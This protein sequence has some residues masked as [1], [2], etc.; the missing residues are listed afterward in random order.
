MLTF[1]PRDAESILDVGCAT[2]HFGTTLRQ[3]GFTGQLWGIEPSIKAVTQA[4][5]RDHY[6]R[7]IHGFYP[8]DLSEHDRFDCV[9]FNDVLEHLQDPWSV[10]SRTHVHLKE[11]GNVVASIPNMRYWP[12]LKQLL[13]HGRWDY[14]DAGILD[15]THLRWFTRSTIIDLFQDTGY[16][17]DDMQALNVNTRGKLRRLRFVLPSLIDELLTLQYGVLASRA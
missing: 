4:R 17:I 14:V 12:A 10:L 15:R 16:R 8:E 6:D 3:W 1:I 7:L 5:A 11:A 2:G 9:V 13:V